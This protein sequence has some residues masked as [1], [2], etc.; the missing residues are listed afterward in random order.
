MS[1]LKGIT[2]EQ[3]QL[4]TQAGRELAENM[5]DNAVKGA[6]NA[7]QMFNQIFTLRA[8]SISILATVMYN[9]VVQGGKDPQERLALYHTVLADEYDMMVTSG[10]VELV[11]V[12][13]ASKEDKGLH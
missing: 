10:E 11:E 4:L 9:D 3:A 1:T 2:V 12:G 7:D 6:A 13:S 8:M 5:M